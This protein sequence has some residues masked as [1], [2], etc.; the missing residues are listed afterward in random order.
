MD[1]N[2]KPLTPD[3]ADQE[4]LAVEFRRAGFDYQTIAEKLHLSGGGQAYKIVQR[5]LKRTI[6]E[7]AEQVRTLELGRLDEMLAGL[8]GPCKAWRYVQR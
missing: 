6:A 2:T 4:R 5:A 7:P 8:Y 1:G 3:R